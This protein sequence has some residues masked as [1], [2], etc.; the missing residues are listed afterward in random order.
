LG[1]GA[2]LAQVA[3]PLIARPWRLASN[4]FFATL[5]HAIALWR[6]H[7]PLLYDQVLQNV[8]MHRLQHVSFLLTAVLFWWSLF[9]GRARHPGYG[10]GVGCRERRSLFGCLVITLVFGKSSSINT[11]KAAPSTSLY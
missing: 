1:N 2:K 5:L 9:C 7:L 10:I 3:H 11:R 8:I 4:P 6:W